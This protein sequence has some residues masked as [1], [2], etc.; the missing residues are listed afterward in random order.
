MK[1]KGLI[2]LGIF[3]I[4]LLLPI[5]TVNAESYT[6]GIV[7]NY[8]VNIRTGPGTWHSI[9]RTIY[10]YSINLSSPESVDVIGEDNGWYHIRFL[11]SGNTYTGY[12]RNDFLNIQ[13]VE[14]DDNYRNSL[15]QKGF[16]DSYADKLAKIHATHPNWDFEPSITHVSLSEAVEYEYSPVYKNLINNDDTN[17]LST[18]GAAYSGGTY[19]QFEPGWY[20]PNKQTIKYYMDPR[21]FLDDGHIFMFEQLSFSDKVTEEY[22]QRALNGTFLQGSYEFNGQQISF[23]KTFLDAGRE[24]NVNPIHLVARVIQEQGPTGGGTVCMD[25]GDGQ[26]YY[27][28]FNFGAT[29]STSAQ[30]IGNALNYAK[31]NGWNNPYYAIRGGA[32]GISDGYINNN[33]DTLYYQKFNIVGGG[34][35]WHQYMANIQA[36]YTESYSTYVSYYRS[37]LID[38]GFIFKIPVYTDMGAST[39][40]ST[41]SSNNNLNSLSISNCSLSPAFDSAITSYSCSVPSGISSVNIKGT[42]ADK[43]SVNGFGDI[44]LNEGEN[45]INIVV[46]AEDGS[47]K[48][49]N[50]TIYRTSASSEDATDVVKSIGLKEN[51]ENISGFKIGSDVSEIIKDIKNKYKNAVV[52]FYDSNNNEIEKGLVAT[53]QKITIIHNTPKTYNIIIKGDTNGDGKVSAI[54]YSKV[55]LDILNTNKLDGVYSIAADTSGDGKISAIDYSKIKSHILKI[56]T[57]EQ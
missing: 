47:K 12:I 28:F 34:Q 6:K 8:G 14:T 52:K 57:L 46:T 11:Y 4:M 13:K 35:Y 23:A 38:T 25:G 33:Q 1:I 40:I 43:A 49:Y 27:N 30:I 3:F 55:K 9:V 44:S 41:K 48:T 20:A 51:G 16:P 36:P 10:G 31:R 5:N 39:L 42:P 19:V 32:E 45:K 21:N 29:G 18:D 50:V 54:D 37:N 7:N 15:V 2:I 56:N 17:L 24:Y 22:V 53:G 26:K